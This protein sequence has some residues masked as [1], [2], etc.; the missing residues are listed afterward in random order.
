MVDGEDPQTSSWQRYIN[1]SLRR[2]NCVA[3][4]CRAFG[5]TLGIYL[6]ASR[7]IEAGSELFSDYGHVYWDSELGSNRLRL[8]RLIVDFL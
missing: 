2:Q 6:E 1:H 3:G 7:P 8:R 4:A 5:H